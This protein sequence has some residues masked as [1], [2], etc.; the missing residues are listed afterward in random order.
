MAAAV[1]GATG[2]RL[3]VLVA[4]ARP[5]PAGRLTPVAGWSFPSGHTTTTTTSAVAA[6][7]AVVMAWP[8]LWRGW[9][10]VVF[11]TAVLGG[12]SWSA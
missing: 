12:P 6:L 1:L 10:R 11:T 2:L 5:G 7:A 8:L 3:V 9:R 4:V